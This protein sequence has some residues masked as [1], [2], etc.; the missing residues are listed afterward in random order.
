MRRRLGFIIWVVLVSLRSTAI[1]AN[2]TIP[3]ESLDDAIIDHVNNFTREPRTGAI[4][5]VSL[6][7]IPSLGGVEVSVL[8]LDLLV[9]RGGFRLLPCPT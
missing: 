2:K 5:N 7:S 3:A 9:Q 1:Q 6:S 4:Y 8:K